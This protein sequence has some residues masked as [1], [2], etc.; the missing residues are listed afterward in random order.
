MIHNNQTPTQERR[1]NAFSQNNRVIS[2]FN[3]FL[4]SLKG[5]KVGIFHHT[6]SDGVSS[7]IILGEL[8]KKYTKKNPKYYPTTYTMLQK[9]IPLQHIKKE[10]IQKALFIDLGIDGQEDFTKKL[11][12]EVSWFLIDHHELYHDADNIIKPQKFTS[13]PASRYPCGKLSYDLAQQH[14]DVTSKDWIACLGIIGDM[15]TEQWKE[16]IDATFKKYGWEKKENYYDTIPGEVCKLETSIEALNDTKKLQQLM[17]TMQKAKRPE[18]VLKSPLRKIHDAVEKEINSTVE[19]IEKENK[20][21]KYIYTEIRPKYDVKSPIST[22]LGVHNP[23]KTLIIISKSKGQY[24]ISGRR[25]DGKY[26]VSTLIRKAIE[27]LP[28]AIGGGHPQA[29]GGS[30]P[31]KYY[32]EFKKRIIEEMKRQI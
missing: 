6:D 11:S 27:E 10:K 26:P 7:G 23:N 21:N 2:F 4:Q 1:E 8:V 30:V 15:A 12:K 25:G 5:K 16:F 9:G 18:D 29:A 22:I 28:G 19:K 32:S 14:M 13:I 17:N 24:H 20:D 3:S 31:T